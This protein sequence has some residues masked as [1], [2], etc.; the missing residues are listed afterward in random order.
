MNDPIKVAQAE[1]ANVKD[2]MVQNIESVLERGERIDLLVNKTNDMSTS[3]RAFRKRSTALR[4]EM[5]W[6]DKK[7]MLAGIGIGLVSYFCLTVVI[8]V[9]YLLL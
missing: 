3:A 4:R 5:W 2:I 7:V 8:V 6:R 9:F 1:L